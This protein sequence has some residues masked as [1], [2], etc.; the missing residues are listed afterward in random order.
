M[1]V[2]EASRVIK[3]TPGA[4]IYASSMRARP[5]ATRQAPAVIAKESIG[6][7]AEATRMAS[8]AC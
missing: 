5:T 8:L 3:T 7:L 4:R 1:R 2:P 6:L